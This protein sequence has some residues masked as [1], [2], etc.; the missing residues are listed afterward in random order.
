MSVAEKHVNDAMRLRRE[1][2]DRSKVGKFSLE[3]AKD[4]EPGISRRSV[5]RYHYL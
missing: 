4:A 1:T 2:I 5:G 3:L